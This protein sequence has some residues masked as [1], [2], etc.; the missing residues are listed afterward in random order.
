MT[1]AAYIAAIEHAVMNEDAETVASIA[2]RLVDTAEAMQILRAKG[3]GTS[4]MDL[5]AMARLV[6]CNTASGAK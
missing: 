2:L 1:P 5:A 3:Y 6:P 4:G